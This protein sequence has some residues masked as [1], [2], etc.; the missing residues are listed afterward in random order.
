MEVQLQIKQWHGS[1]RHTFQAE[2]TVTFKLQN[3]FF[4]TFLFLER[5]LVAVEVKT[6]EYCFYLAYCLQSSDT[7]CCET[8]LG[9]QIPFPPT[10]QLLK[11]PFGLSTE[12]SE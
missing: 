12:N 3:F 10:K 5:L 9:F 6:P 2:I 8:D 1:V 4:F 7:K 11:S